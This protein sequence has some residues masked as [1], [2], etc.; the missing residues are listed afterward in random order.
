MHILDKNIGLIATCF[1]LMFI[2]CSDCS[3]D[4]RWE[5]LGHDNVGISSIIY[6]DKISVN[7]SLYIEIRGSGTT[8]IN[9]TAS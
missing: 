2:R 3:D 1:I 6:E 5:F 7:D 9:R 4:E 8:P